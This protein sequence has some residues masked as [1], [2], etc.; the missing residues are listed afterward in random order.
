MMPIVDKLIG[1]GK[2]ITKLETWHNE[3]NAGKLEKVDAG[4]CGG[5]PFFHNTGTDQFICG[6]TDEARIRDWADGKKFE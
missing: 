3:E 1:E 4:R 5:V 6:S 2:E